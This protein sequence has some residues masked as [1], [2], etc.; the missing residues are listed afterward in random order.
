V[1]VLHIVAYFAPAFV[2]GGPPRTVL[3]LCRA[4]QKGGVDVEVFT[5]TANGSSD[6]PPSPKSGQIFEGIPVHYFARHFPKQFF[7]APDLA[8]ALSTSVRQYD[9]I[10]V[11]GLWNFTVWSAVQAVRKASVPYIV[12]PRGMLDSGSLAHQKWRKIVGYHLIERSGLKGAARLHATSDY[13]MRRLATLGFADKTFELPNGVDVPS[14]SPARGCFRR[15]INVEQ[16]APLV[17]YLGRIHP[18]KRLD[19][20][21]AAF[22]RLHANCPAAR[23]VIAGPDDEQSLHKLRPLFQSFAAAVTWTGELTPE[24]KWALLH[25]ST[26]LVMC[27]DSE[28]FGVAVVEAMAAKVPVVVTR[29]CPWQVIEEAQCGFWVEQDAAAISEAL[30][31]IVYNPS[32]AAEMGLRG[33]A[34]AKAQYSW[35]SIAAAMLNHYG[36]VLAEWRVV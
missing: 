6:F 11:H 24:E 21:A 7:R 8:A 36:E 22:Q 3:G 4:L 31:R 16:S 1:R 33:F 17:T 5:T 13:E 27:S 9:L 18:T 26:L 28:S 20:L 2:Y 32:E 12:S 35:S 29:T 30:S 14:D 25:D 23:L 10:H 15:K 34:L 19:L